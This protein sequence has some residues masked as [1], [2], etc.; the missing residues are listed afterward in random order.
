MKK[1][2]YPLVGF[3][4]FISYY[5]NAQTFTATS[6]P[7]TDYLNTFYIQEIPIEVKGLPTTVDEV[8]GF[9][10][11]NL[12]LHHTRTSDLKIQLQAPDGTTC[13]I[14]N[15]NGTS[16][17]YDNTNFSQFGKDGLINKANNPFTGNFIPDGQITY[18]NNGSNP[19]GTWKL[20]IEDLRVEETGFLDSVSLTFGQNPA[21]LKKQQYCSFDNE[22]YCVPSNNKEGVLL[23]DLVIVPAFSKMQ[24]QEFS[25][26]DAA[27]PSQLKISVAIANI[28]LG[29]FEVNTDTLV[30][31]NKSDTS[32]EKRFQLN[33]K[34]YA[35]NNRK[36]T[37]K[38]YKAGTI[39]FEPKPGHQHYHVDDWIEMRLVKVSKG[40]RKTVSKGSKVSY[41][42][43]TTGMLY[44]NES[45]S[46]IDKIHYGSTMPNYGLGNYNSCALLE[47]GITVGGY[48]YYGLNYEGQYLQLPK[49]LKNGNYTLE[50][51]I[52]PN[53]LYVESNRKNNTFSMP[54]MIS[55]Q[56]D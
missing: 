49:G 42:L 15:R 29:P 51:E 35:L 24:Y 18:F 46:I 30:N 45:S 12:T 28:G 14:T 22:K 34:I 47:Q 39:Y 9:E 6:A 36:F 54:I 2:F 32:I 52:D 48:D 25:P 21:V 23:P 40:K 38:T 55:K 16:S 26:T 41:C 50:I 44:E 31:I 13:W 20:L 7:I 56:E 3:L 10:S 1:S 8:F 27:F 19:N 11:L 33:Q 4:F 37:S 43:F 5:T 53:H 17:N